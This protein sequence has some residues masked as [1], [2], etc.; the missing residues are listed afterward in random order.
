IGKKSLREV[1]EADWPGIIQSKLSYQQKNIISK[2][3]P[4]S[5]TLPNGKKCKLLY[6]GFKQP[7]MEARI[8]ELFGWK[9]SPKLAKGRSTPLI[10]LLAP[11]YRSQ[12]LTSDLAGFW[13]TTY[14]QVRKDLRSRYPKH[15]WPEDPLNE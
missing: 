7:F 3:A 2:E 11:N 15:K 6:D 5:I 4:D 12:Q 10:S 14:S 13:K 9:E 8:Q 1:V